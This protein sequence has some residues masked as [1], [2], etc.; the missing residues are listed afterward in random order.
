MAD[1]AK[2]RKGRQRREAG[3]QPKKAEPEVYVPSKT[4]IP[5]DPR[6]WVIVRP[7]VP[8]IADILTRFGP[9]EEKPKIEVLTSTLVKFYGKLS[10]PD[11]VVNLADNLS[12]FI[13]QRDHFSAGPKAINL[14]QQRADAEA[15]GLE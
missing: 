8:E 5:E 13:A 12:A 14:V 7:S 6:W 10:E 9:W 1:K 3:E 2:E 15:A 4:E 11:V